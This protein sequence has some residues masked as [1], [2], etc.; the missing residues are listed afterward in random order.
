[1]NNHEVTKKVT[2]GKSKSRFFKKGFSIKGLWR[3]KDSVVALAVALFLGLSVAP[4]Y[5]SDP[6]PT[7]AL[8]FDM[9][10]MFEWAQMILNM[11]MPVLYITLGVSLAFIIVR[12]LKQAFN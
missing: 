4:G 11:M 6:E 5:C 9:A 1:M 10:E 12:A 3:V 2:L 8:N 7:L